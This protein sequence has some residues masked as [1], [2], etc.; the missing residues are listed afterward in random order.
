MVSMKIENYEGTASTFTF[1]NNPRVFDDELVSN[2]E[3]TTLDLRQRHVISSGNGIAPKSLVL[4]GF[5]HGASR[6][7]NYRTLTGHWHESKKLK[8][9]YFESDKFY[10]GVGKQIKQTNTGGRTNFVDYVAT[11]Q[12]IVGILFGDTQKTSGTNDGNVETFVEEIS[13]STKGVDIT[14]SD[15]LG[16][17]IKI[18]NTSSGSAFSLKFV[19]MKDAAAGISISKYNYCTIGGVEK[20]VETTSGT[21]MIKIDAGANMT[22]IEASPSVALTTVLT[23]PVVTFRDAYSS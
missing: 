15:N 5:F 4:T 3:I 10:L 13:G 17:A 14:I 1:P 12:A 20:F 8:K 19:T 18:A 7:T 2:S 9:L 23:T 16:N 6:R 11:F 21:G 22:T